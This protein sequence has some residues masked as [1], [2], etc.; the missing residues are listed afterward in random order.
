[1]IVV[2]SEPA[3]NALM[4]RWEDNG[5]GVPEVMKEKIFERGFGRNTGLGLFL[6]K[7][8][9]ALTGITIRETGTFGSGARFEIF[10]PAGSFRYPAA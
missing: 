9:L 8:I 5:P 6:A 2:T 3:G 4:I 7:E 10:V 1:M